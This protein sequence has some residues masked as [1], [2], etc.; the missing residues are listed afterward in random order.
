MSGKVVKL[1]RAFYGVK[2]TDRKWSALLC[3]TLVDKFSMKQ[4]GADPC[5]SWKIENKE[6]VLIMVLY[7]DDVLVSQNE[8]VCK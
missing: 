3:M 6:M 8:T 5:A 1:E 2:Q 7:V 4:C